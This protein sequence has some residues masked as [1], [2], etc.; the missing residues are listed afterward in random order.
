MADSAPVA[1]RRR[2]A[3]RLNCAECRRL[4]LRCDR[5]IPC[6]SCI[7]RGCGAICPDG[8]LTAGQGGRYILATA[9]ELHQKHVEMAYRIRSLEDA[10]AALQAQ[11]STDT[12][13]LLSEEL[14]KIKN[15]LQRGAY[16]SSTGDT[17]GSM[18]IQ[19]CGEPRYY[20]HAANSCYFVQNH[21]EI[22]TETRETTVSI[23][24]S[25]ELPPKILQRASEVS[26]SGSGYSD[27]CS[28]RSLLI[29]LPSPTIT[30][31]LWTIYHAHAGWMY[32]PISAEVFETQVFATFY[33]P[34]AASDL[35]S[36]DQILFQKLSLLFMVLAIGSLMDSTLPSYNTPA[37]RY[38]QLARAAL[39]QTSIFDAPSL[40]AVQAL[41]LM[42]LYLFLADRHGADSDAMWA[43]M[44]LAIR[45][46]QTVSFCIHRDSTL[47][48]FD[49]ADVRH[50]RELFWEI[51]S[52]DS[53]QCLT[54]GRP[55][56]FPLSHVD[57][58]QPYLGDEISHDEALVHAWKHSFTSKCM[59]ALHDQAFGARGST[60]T[61]TLE[62]DYKIRAFPVP[63]ILTRSGQLETNPLGSSTAL[64]LTLQ[65]H[66]VAAIR[67]SSL[68]YLH[69][70]FF[71]RA[72]R[73]YPANPLRSP[74]G[75]SVE[76]IFQ[77][78]QELVTLMP[79]LYAQYKEPCERLWFLWAHIFSCSVILASIV[80]HSPSINLAPSAL[81]HLDTA[82]SL[83]SN[84]AAGFRATQILD[85]MRRLQRKAHRSLKDYQQGWGHHRQLSSHSELDDT[86]ELT[87]LKGNINLGSASGSSSPFPLGASR[88][89]SSSPLTRPS[90]CS[91]FS[92]SGVSSSQDSQI[93]GDLSTTNGVYVAQTPAFQVLDTPL[94]IYTQPFFESASSADPA[95]PLD[96]TDA[97]L[98]GMT[99]PF[100]DNV[101]SGGCDVSRDQSFFG[102]TSYTYGEGLDAGA[103]W[104]QITPTSSGELESQ[105]HYGGPVNVQS[106]WN[107]LITRLQL[108][109]DNNLP[110]Q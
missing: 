35:M 109:S 73:D 87:M 22:E 94:S 25:T 6:S 86:E 24:L 57:C 23:L 11:V 81:A 82:C 99:G 21:G 108:S 89:L 2:G 37:E 83:F 66:V 10:L 51:F 39:F 49:A 52:Y 95:A 105:E 36:E 13:H 12:H 96:T 65:R 85:I 30:R 14:L 55:P 28:L 67:E 78:A 62:L 58:S 77:S 60:Y 100:M 31:A 34:D 74:F 79:T 107:E 63:T 50:R 1:K 80:I 90:T 53:L 61:T 76:A 32:N 20:G 93:A 69:R 41:F 7:K 84:V 48:A 5:A 18:S 27:D 75:A 64:I 72:I 4:K 47:W 44:G 54:F 33:G 45:V 9:G 106:E 26:I 91:S 68:L 103:G 15:P 40:H 97:A 29:Y 46:A 92:S 102:M 71:A 110:F 16:D 56:S 98:F 59:S 8:S 3:P 19:A 42:S 88:S 101:N 104:S 38:H 70:S 43:I 17:S